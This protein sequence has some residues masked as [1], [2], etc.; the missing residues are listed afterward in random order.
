MMRDA[1][2][3][4]A[5]SSV[6]NESFS[7]QPSSIRHLT[8][9]I[10]HLTSDIGHPPSRIPIPTQTIM[11]RKTSFWLLV[12]ASL[13]APLFAQQTHEKITASDGATNDIFGVAVAIDGDYALVGASG[14]DDMGSNAGAAYVFK[15]DSNAWQEHAKLTAS[16]GEA[17]HEF[18]ISVAISGNY[19]LVGASRT[20]A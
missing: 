10:R 13:A 14:D 20:S 4:M 18:G 12:G 8:S 19:A 3:Q 15:H 17:D 9:A 5:E 7:P 6:R 16:D 11:Y 1:G 2:Y